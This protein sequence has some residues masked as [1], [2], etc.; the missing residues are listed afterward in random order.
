MTSLTE[1]QI[2]NIFKSE[3]AVLSMMIRN[4]LDDIRDRLSPDLRRRV[5]VFEKQYWDALYD[6]ATEISGIVI[7]YL[8]RDKYLFAEEIARFHPAGP[9][10][11]TV[12]KVADTT[13]VGAAWALIRQLRKRTSTAA[14]VRHVLGD[15]TLLWACCE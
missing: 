13:E 14:D 10:L 6:R 1:K 7:K 15:P 2:D 4:E 3:Y 12:F 9:A 5:E 11:F 8:A